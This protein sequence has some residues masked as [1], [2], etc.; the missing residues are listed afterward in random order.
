[1][2]V[3]NALAAA[4]LGAGT[5]PG[6]VIDCPN[7]AE[8]TLGGAG[9]APDRVGPGARARPLEPHPDQG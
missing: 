6:L 8:I 4:N 3:Q 1:M 5:D 9:Q 2:Q 7:L